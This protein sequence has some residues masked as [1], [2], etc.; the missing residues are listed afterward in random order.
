[1]TGNT[2]QSDCEQDAC[3]F[4]QHMELL[5][6]GCLVS[7]SDA[8]RKWEIKVD[9]P[10]ISAMDDAWALMLV[11]WQEQGGYDAVHTISFG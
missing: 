2:K 1:M 4:L 11:R 8:V 9:K 5:A 7:L 6:T 3:H 10:L